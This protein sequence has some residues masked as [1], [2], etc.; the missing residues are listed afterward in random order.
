MIFYVVDCLA[1]SQA[2]VV[3]FW[4]IFAIHSHRNGTAAQQEAVSQWLPHAQI[5]CCSQQLHILS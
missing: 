1:H 5:M 2:G 3:K 4:V